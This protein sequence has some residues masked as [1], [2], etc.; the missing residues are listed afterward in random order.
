MF[1]INIY[2]STCRSKII[3]IHFLYDHIIACYNVSH[4]ECKYIEYLYF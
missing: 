3:S 2:V 1:H 4:E